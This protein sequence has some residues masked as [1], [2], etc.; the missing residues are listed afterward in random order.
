MH[1]VQ[2]CVEYSLSTCWPNTDAWHDTLLHGMRLH[3]QQGYEEA[4][5]TQQ[6]LHNELAAHP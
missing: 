1:D 4:D 6:C 2:H 3:C 5:V